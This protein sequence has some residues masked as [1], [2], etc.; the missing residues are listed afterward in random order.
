MTEIE[1]IEAIDARFFFDTNE[2]YEHVTRI[3][4][5]LSD[6]AVLM[7]GY[8][9]AT[10]SSHA[11]LETN[12]GLLQIMKDKRPTPVILAALPVI[13]SLLKKEKATSRDMQVLFEAVRRHGSAWNGL[14]IVECADE[15]SKEACEEI[16]ASWRKNQ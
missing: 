2:E 11:S 13:E 7:I 1:F 10:L 3:A 9:L 4:C 6:N 16:R 5:S 15:R 8:E 14:G 12:L